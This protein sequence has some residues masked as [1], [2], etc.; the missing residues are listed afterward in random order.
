MAIEDDDYSDYGSD[1]GR[2]A[3]GTSE[4]TS[5]GED[6]SSGDSSSSGFDFNKLLTNL[7]GGKLGEG[8]STPAGGLTGLLGLYALSQMGKTNPSQY[9]G[10]TG[11]IPKL[12]A[13]RQA[14]QQPEYRPYSG[15]P[16]MGRQFFSPITYGP[17]GSAAAPAASAPTAAPAPATETTIPAPAVPRP[18]SP[19]FDFST[20]PNISAA[21][22]GAEVAPDEAVHGT[23]G[24]AHGGLM[25]LASG[26]YLRGG[27]DG[28]AD[29]I[30]SS[31]D[32]AQ[33]A[34]LSHGEF[35][36]P[37]DVVSHLGNGNSD[38]GA[39]VLYKMMDR[40]R[41]A[42]TGTTKQGHKINPEKFTPGGQAYADGGAVAFSTGAAVPAA[43]AANTAASTGVPVS[44]SSTLSPWVG[45]YV[46][47]MLGRGAALADMQ[48]QPYQGPLTA[49]TSP[50]QRQGWAGLSALVGG[51]GMGGY[52]GGF[53]YKPEM[54]PRRQAL[55]MP[56]GGGDVVDPGY[57]GIQ[58]AVSPSQTGGGIED[59]SKMY[60]APQGGA[61][62]APWQYNL[63]SSLAAQAGLGSFT[64]P[65]TAEA[66]MSPYMQNVV[67]VQQAEAKRQAQ[68]AGTQRG[69]Q[70]AKAGAFGGARQ[71]IE[72][73]EAN[74][75]LQTQLGGI[76]AQGLQSAYNQAQQQYNAE[77]NAQLQAAMNLGSLGA[78]QFGTQ[79]SGI[80]A[81]L[82][83]GQTQ[84]GQE[85]AGITAL[86]N[87]YNKQ[88]MWPY[89]QLQFQQS[90]LGGLPIGTTTA[91]AQT[92]AL[93]QLGQMI[94]GLGGIYGTLKG[95][96]S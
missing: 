39:D 81:L 27:T 59:L 33:P 1:T 49:G 25:Q 18:T 5:T 17:A 83:A 23:G 36:V 72:N 43:S 74:R 15:E 73:A 66:F 24:A 96:G 38:A 85:Q 12:T 79:L 19:G 67:D 87:E 11:S 62:N 50:L 76:Q 58:P 51:G 13:T 86:Q 6:D 30:P 37:A 26:R 22:G 31:I 65:K 69:A 21:M 77:R 28:M 16:V 14:L 91:A 32:G 46:T 90:L 35:V 52:G 7:F 60:G 84:Y 68:I 78:G 61:P 3:A 92:G 70:Y 75:N 93:G 10:Y 47:N 57:G 88:M 54:P 41:K 56:Q 71:A 20:I 48:Y 45:D 55:G 53:G 29:K 2:G 4:T 44:Q 9:A 34:K 40:V 80:N 64:Q 94:S 63:G 89:Q 42:R 82:G 95:F 8:L